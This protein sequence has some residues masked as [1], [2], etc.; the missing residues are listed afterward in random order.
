LLKVY[1]S[2]DEQK[3]KFPHNS[4]FISLYCYLL[5]TK[6]AA[7]FVVLCLA[8]YLYISVQGLTKMKAVCC[9]KLWI[10]KL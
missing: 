7:A 5:T 1:N 4:R 3:I 2:L 10:D 9:R 6:K 8:G